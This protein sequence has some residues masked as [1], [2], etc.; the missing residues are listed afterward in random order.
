MIRNEIDVKTLK[1]ISEKTGGR[2]FRATDKEALSDIYKEIDSL[3]RS[4]IEIRDF[5][6]YQELYMFLLFPALILGFIM[7][8]LKSYYFKV[9]V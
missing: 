3:E 9:R 5:T 2:F 7:M 8:I 4:F 6:Q 1:E